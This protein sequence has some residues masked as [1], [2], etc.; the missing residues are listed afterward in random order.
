MYSH[1]GE[2]GMSKAADEEILAFALREHAT[3]VT[4]DADFHAILAV[5]GASGPR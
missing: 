3:L 2:I 1:V 4:L 5:S